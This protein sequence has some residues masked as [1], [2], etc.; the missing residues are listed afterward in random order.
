MSVRKS[1]L[2]DFKIFLLSIG[3]LTLTACGERAP[4]QGDEQNDAEESK[5]ESVEDHGDG[6]NVVQNTD[7]ASISTGA[8]TTVDDPFTPPETVYAVG[9][10][11]GRGKDFYNEQ[12]IPALADNGCAKCHA[13]GYV[14]PNVFIYEELIRRLA[15]GESAK[16][17]VV[18]YKLANTRSISPEIPNHPG[19]QRCAT[20]DDDPCNS[21]RRWWEIE[22][23]EE[24]VRDE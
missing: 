3:A 1:S 4:K 14:R 13:R 17:N 22:F 19:G 12:V 21:I 24:V 2:P 9:S 23:G 18:I 11:F 5:S 8:A 10:G 16:N 15:I 20:I 7:T 6:E